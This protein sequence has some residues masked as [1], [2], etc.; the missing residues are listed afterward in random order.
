LNGEVQF[1]ACIFNKLRARSRRDQ[2]SGIWMS[3]I[4][5]SH[6][7]RSEDR[8][9]GVASFS[10]GVR[11]FHIPVRAGN[12]P[13]QA[14][15]DVVG[16]FAPNAFI[17]IDHSGKT[18]LVT[19]QVEMGQDVYTSIPMILAEEL[20]ADFSQ[21]ALEHAPPND[22]LYANPMFGYQVTGNSNSVRAWWKPLRA[23]GA[24]VRAMLVQAAAEEWSVEPASC[25]TAN[26][27]CLIGLFRSQK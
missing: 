15:D 25:K 7:R 27:A 18:A 13:V 23:A 2:E 14:P 16:K 9:R 5:A 20:D 8:G 3:V 12:E 4:G 22:R 21:V 1:G 26:S 19:P 24:S 6:G 11:A 17:R 10:I